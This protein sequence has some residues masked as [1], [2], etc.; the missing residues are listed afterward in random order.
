MVWTSVRLCAWLEVLVV[1]FQVSGVAALC[2]YRLAPA[3]R[4]GARGRV[5]FVVAMVG[6]GFAGALC[7]RNDSEFGLFAGAT[8]TFLL[9]GMTAGSGHVDT[10]APT[11][12]RVSA[13]PNLAG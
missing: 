10:T 3:T 12:A 7:G 11:H 9:V 6:L 13:E 4:W 2:L 1:L 5:G 8:M